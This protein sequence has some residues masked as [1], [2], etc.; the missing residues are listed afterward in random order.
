MLES[1]EADELRLPRSY[2]KI[3]PEP[4]SGGTADMRILPHLMSAD[5]TN[6]FFPTV[7]LDEGGETVGERI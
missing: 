6:D 4:S 3:L 5:E 2:D 1:H 7:K